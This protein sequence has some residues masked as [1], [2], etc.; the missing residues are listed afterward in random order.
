M[1]FIVIDQC[2]RKFVV[3]CLQVRQERSHVTI[4]HHTGTI[5]TAQSIIFAHAIRRIILEEA[6][7]ESLTHLL[8]RKTQTILPTLLIILFDSKIATLVQDRYWV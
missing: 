3:E 5:C 7:R 6:C 1:T 8:V 4:S 2:I